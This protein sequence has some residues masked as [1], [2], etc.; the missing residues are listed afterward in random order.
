MIL[1]GIIDSDTVNYKKISMVL[2]FP[3]CSWKCDRDCGKQVCQNSKLATAPNI[4]ISD[5]DIIKMYKA[6]PLHEALVCQG[7]EPFDSL[8][9][10]Y[11]FVR[12]FREKSSDDIVIYTG[13]TVEEIYMY[14]EEF[15]RFKNIII[16]LGRF[17]PDDESR[18]DPLLG[19]TLASS[20][21]YAIL[22]S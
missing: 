5:D 19:V 4:E 1:K 20:N 15:K 11:H 9:D 12:K 17:I 18:Y 21:Q 6:N 10:I 7:L 3:T 8:G 14:I 13:Y 16:K 2:E 22:I